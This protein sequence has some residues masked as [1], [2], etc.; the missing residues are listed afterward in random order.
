MLYSIH[1]AIYGGTMVMTDEPRQLIDVASQQPAS[2]Q[3]RLA[4]LIRRELEVIH[5]NAITAT[6]EGQITLECLAAEARAE[7]ARGEV[8]DGGWE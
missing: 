8:E 6:P 5:W 7:I 3:R 1:A 2:V 4:E